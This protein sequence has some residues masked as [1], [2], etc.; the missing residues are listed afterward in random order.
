M[1]EVLRNLNYRSMPSYRVEGDRRLWGN[2]ERFGSMSGTGIVGADSVVWPGEA[3]NPKKKGPTHR[4]DPI[5]FSVAR[6]RCGMGLQ[7]ADATLD[8]ETI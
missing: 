6:K 8:A 1:L 3:I 2:L 5:S 4:A 7:Q